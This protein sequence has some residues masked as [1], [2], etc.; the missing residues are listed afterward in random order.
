[1]KY[2]K[3]IPTEAEH[4]QVNTLVMAKVKSYKKWPA[5][6][7]KKSGQKCTVLFYGSNDTACLPTD[8]IEE[9]DSTR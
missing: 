6:I 4:L 8:R 1:M 2:A 7:I 3:M 9:F 5:K